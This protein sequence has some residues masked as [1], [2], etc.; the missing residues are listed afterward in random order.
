[1][2][3]SRHADYGVR[4]MVDVASLPTG[5]RAITSE[6]AHRQDIPRVFLTKIIP[7]LVSAGL[8]RSYRGEGGGIVLGRP[9][10]TITLLEVYESL[11]GP[12]AIN[13]CTSV[14]AQCGR[15]GQCSVHEVWLE[16]QYRL[17][18]LMGRTLLSH[19]AERQSS[20]EWGRARQAAGVKR[21]PVV[22]KRP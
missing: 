8:L 9:A 5:T 22:K 21:L 1:M 4:A 2:R 17:R 20:I 14:P 3:L 7:R 11:D 12:I 16:A 15:A 18:E 10:D 13:R 6:V 19:L